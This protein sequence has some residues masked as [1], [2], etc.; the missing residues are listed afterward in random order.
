MVSDVFLRGL[1]PR[2]LPSMVAGDIAGAGRLEVV[3]WVLA[4]RA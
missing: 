4:L 1:L 3:F 2:T